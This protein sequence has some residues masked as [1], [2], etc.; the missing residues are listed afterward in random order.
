[1]SAT[2]PSRLEEI[3]DR[4]GVAEHI[5]AL[6][7]IGVRPRQLRVRTLLIGMLL[8]LQ[9]SRPAH[10]RRAH[11]ALLSLTEQ[12]RRRLGVIAQW[13]DAPHLL[14]YRQVERTF[15]LI[16]RALS[17]EKPDGSPAE[18]LS[19]AMDALVEASVQILGPPQSSA[20]AV[21]WTDYESF[22]RPPRKKTRR[23]RAGPRGRR[24][25]DAKQ[26]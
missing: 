2:M 10:L 20:L 7:P 4:S 13:K 22:Y 23:G 18:A 26:C 5:E 17:K 15:G 1:M 16:V 11:Q 19:D 14:T 21:D 9:D 6:L 25:A 8:C 24:A 12:E 3:V